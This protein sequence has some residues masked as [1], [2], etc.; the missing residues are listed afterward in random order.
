MKSSYGPGD[1]DEVE[2]GDARSQA[3]S[4]ALKAIMETEWVKRPEEPE[5]DEDP[6]VEDE[7]QNAE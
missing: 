3:A 6:T 2:E 4:N 1:E 5:I 7:I